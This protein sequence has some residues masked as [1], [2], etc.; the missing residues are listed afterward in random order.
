[1]ASSVRG[2]IHRSDWLP[3]RARW[4]CLVRLGLNAVSRKSSLTISFLVFFTLYNKFFL[5]RA[6]S[7]KMAGF[8]FSLPVYGPRPP[9]SIHKHTK[10]QQHLYFFQYSYNY[11]NTFLFL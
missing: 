9:V 8:F 1:M 10:Q 3:E 2:Q 5:D 7:V 6:W 11:Y 4:H